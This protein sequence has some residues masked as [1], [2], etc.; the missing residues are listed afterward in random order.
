MRIH[1]K[2]SRGLRA[3]GADRPCALFRSKDAVALA[4]SDKPSAG[5]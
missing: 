3:F 2:F 4:I 1:G 5:D